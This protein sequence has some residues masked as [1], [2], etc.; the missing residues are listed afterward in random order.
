MVTPLFRD[1][2]ESTCEST[3]KIN[4]QFLMK[5]KY[6]RCE[7]GIIQELT[8]L[9]CFDLQEADKLHCSPEKIN[10]KGQSPW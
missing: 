7:S 6:K 10:Q 9:F 1:T 5:L 3:I 8:H 2:D 4:T